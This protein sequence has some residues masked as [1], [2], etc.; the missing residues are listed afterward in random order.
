[1][2][3]LIEFAGNHTLLVIAL[4][5]ILGALTWNL[6]AGGGKN[7]IPPH[8]ATGLIN[9]EEAVVVDVRPIADFNKGHIVN[10]INLPINGFKNQIKQLEKHKNKP[11]IVGCRSGNQSQTACRELRKAGFENVY[12]LRGGVFAWQSANLPL[13]RKKK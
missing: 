7:N 10:S 9:R 3:Q 11:I 1:M 13:S 4:F 12:N 2:E 8:E 5:V 6:L